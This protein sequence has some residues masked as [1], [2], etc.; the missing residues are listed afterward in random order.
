LKWGIS[1][2]DFWEMSL[3]ELERA[4]QSRKIIK[5]REAQEQATFDYILADLVGRSV[6]RIY[7]STNK[8]PDICDVYPTLFDSEE[9]KQK[10]QEQ[11]TKLSALRFKQ[12]THSF[13][14][15]FNKEV[16]K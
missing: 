4:I 13:N 10:K 5:E 1:E 14:S 7:A 2:R 15:K 12:F 11:Q 16:S 3:C 8:L 6:G 9:I